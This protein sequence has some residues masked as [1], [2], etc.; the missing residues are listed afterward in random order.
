[1]VLFRLLYF[2][3]P[4]T[5][6]LATLGLREIYVSLV[7]GKKIKGEMPRYLT[8]ASDGDRAKVEVK[9]VSRDIEAPTDA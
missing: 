7:E 4:F 1:L 3:I 9:K 6:A 8:F 5:C 2:V